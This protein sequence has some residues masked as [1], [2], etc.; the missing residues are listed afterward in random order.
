MGAHDEHED[1]IEELRKAQFKA[2]QP[3]E[4]YI[5]MTPG[6]EGAGW[7]GE[8]FAEPDKYE[9]MHPNGTVLLNVTGLSE[10]DRAEALS[11]ARSDYI[12]DPGTVVHRR[13]EEHKPKI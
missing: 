4:P 11:E 8:D 5:R 2:S 3:R 13:T 6:K 9:I 1:W 10:K 7:G 12:A